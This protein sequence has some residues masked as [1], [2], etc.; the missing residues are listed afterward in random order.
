MR[1]FVRLRR[2]ISAVA[3]FAII[4]NSVM[5]TIGMTKAALQGQ[6]FPVAE[7]CTSGG[8]KSLAMIDGASVA[9]DLGKVH[10]PCDYCG[11]HAGTF[12]LHDTRPPI[13]AVDRRPFLA[14]RLFALA[15]DPLFSWAAHGSRAPPVLS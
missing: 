11:A 5:S 10:K 6:A 8:M 1:T 12:A 13:V 3:L 15:H 9:A 7:I 2:H 4:L 14:P